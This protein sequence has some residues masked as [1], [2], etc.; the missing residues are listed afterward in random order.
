[1]QHS[2][3]LLRSSTSPVL[4]ILAVPGRRE[5]SEHTNTRTA[6][7]RNAYFCVTLQL[8]PS[9][10][11]YAVLNWSPLKTPRKCP[12]RLLYGSQKAQIR[13]G[14]GKLGSRAGPVLLASFVHRKLSSVRL[15]YT[16]QKFM[17]V[18]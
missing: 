15:S 7:F 6:K 18:T 11:G 16:R 9:P 10:L 1:M 17:I 13:T 3:I 14:R 2:A 12:A 4:G 8:S 5:N